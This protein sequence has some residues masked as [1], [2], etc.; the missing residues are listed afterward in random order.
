M[1]TL[2]CSEALGTLSWLDVEYKLCKSVFSRSSPRSAIVAVEFAMFC[3]VR[4]IL[5]YCLHIVAELKVSVINNL[6]TMSG[7]HAVHERQAIL[8]TTVVISNTFY[9]AKENEL[10]PRGAWQ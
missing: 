9:M 4:R 5:T 6:K 8:L 10:T 1:R 3:R 7:G 2:L